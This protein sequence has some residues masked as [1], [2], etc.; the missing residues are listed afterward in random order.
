MKILKF[1]Y[2]VRSTFSCF[3]CFAI[4]QKYCFTIMPKILSKN[5]CNCSCCMFIRIFE[6]HSKKH[7]MHSYLYVWSWSQNL[8]VS[9]DFVAIIKSTRT[10]QNPELYYSCFRDPCMH[11]YMLKPPLG[12]LG[13]TPD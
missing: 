6:V 5:L 2:S 11:L 9:I 13:S 8:N 10:K 4:M 3:T 12:N 7:Y 1:M